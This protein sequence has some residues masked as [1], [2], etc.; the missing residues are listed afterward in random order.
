MDLLVL[1][2]LFH[3]PARSPPFSS[4]FRSAPF[5][6]T[7]LGLDTLS[8]SPLYLLCLFRP[9]YFSMHGLSARWIEKR[10][11]RERT[12]TRRW[13]SAQVAVFIPPPRTPKDGRKIVK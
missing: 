8:L 9:G 5:V 12:E 6:F 1:S 3:P 2:R 13:E 10:E 11:G 7:S 4:L